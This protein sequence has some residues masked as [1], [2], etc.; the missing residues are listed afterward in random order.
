MRQVFLHAD[1]L[2]QRV[3]KHS[4]QSSESRVS[5]NRPFWNIVVSKHRPPS[6]HTSTDSKWGYE[7]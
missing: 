7:L 6:W 3:Y 2:G 4:S 1:H 5:V